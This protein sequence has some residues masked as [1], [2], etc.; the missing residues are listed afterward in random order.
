M[1]ENQL[2]IYYFKHFQYSKLGKDLLWLIQVCSIVDITIKDTFMFSF[3]TYHWV[4]KTTGATSGAI[5]VYPYPSGARES[6]PGF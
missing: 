4:C 3:M 6:S 2:Q 1:I 5:T